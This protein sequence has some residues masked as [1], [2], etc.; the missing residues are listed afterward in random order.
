MWGDRKRLD[1]ITLQLVYKRKLPSIYGQLGKDFKEVELGRE[2]HE[3]L[4]KA[5]G[6]IFSLTELVERLRRGDINVPFTARACSRYYG[7]RCLPDVVY[8]TLRR[9][10]P[11]PV[12]EVCIVE[13]KKEFRPTYMLQLYAMAII[14][15]D[16]HVMV[17]AAPD[18][19][20][21]DLEREFIDNGT[22]LY[23]FLKKELDINELRVDVYISLNVYK[24]SAKPIDKPLFKDLFSR[25]FKVDPRFY[26]QFLSAR[27]RRNE[28]IKAMERKLPYLISSRQ[29]HFT[30]RPS[31]RG[32]AVWKL[33]DK[34]RLYLPKS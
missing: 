2:A 29:T 14:F 25:D 6:V 30:T 16:F 15:T 8:F 19:T 3:M 11:V 5:R 18:E 33:D 4:Q 34:Y 7:Q 31:R 20:L 28:I 9:D 22:F 27:R 12:L 21:A 24:D 1:L 23:D 32:R 10:L 26:S 17:Q 13:D